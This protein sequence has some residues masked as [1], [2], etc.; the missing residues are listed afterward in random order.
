M[1]QRERLDAAIDA[2][3]AEAAGAGPGAA[4]AARRAAALTEG[5]GGPKALRAFS[6]A[7]RHD[8]LDAFPRLALA[9]LH[10]EAGDLDAARREAAAVLADA[11][12]EAARARAAFIL[13]ELARVRGAAAEARDAYAA[14]AR[15]EDALLSANP[16]DATAA[17]W[18]ARALGRLSELDAPEQ[19][20]KAR[21]G[22]EGALSILRALTAQIGEPPPLAADIADAE[23][24]YA[25]LLLD[26]GHAAPA[27]LHT[28]EATGRYEALILLE[29]NEPHW[30]AAL[31]EAWT[32]CA[33]AAFQSNAPDA[34]REA[35]DKALRLRLKLAD[36]DPNEAW[37][38]AGLWRA[39]AA[40]LAALGDKS[41][42]ADSALQAVAL[43]KRLHGEA[44]GDPAGARFL[45]HA[46][47]E[48]SDLALAQGALA[49][50]EDAATQ[51]RDLAERFAQAPNAAAHWTADCATAWD[52]LAH[53][54]LSTRASAEAKE[55]FAK[56]IALRRRAREAAP[57]DDNAKRALARA[58][59]RSG[60]V[61]LASRA[62]PAAL[63]AFSEAFQLRLELAEAAPGAMEPARELAV[64]L[65]RLGLSAAADGDAQ[66][67]R[68]VWEE[69]LAL[70]ERVYEDPSDI[71]GQRF[72]AV[73]EAHLASLG[74]P[75]S[76]VRR[77]SAL[78]R[79]DIMA[80]DGLLTPRDVQLRQSL[81]KTG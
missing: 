32:L 45:L 56:A 1:T 58:L 68:A 34:A 81:W 24:R 29:P 50:A 69:E 38:L 5:Q 78:A 41:A 18:Y 13:G 47:L 64:A 80:E 77:A 20:E 17:R 74:G 61:A 27:R 70:V 9:R 76:A 66:G 57:E 53:V 3:L 31:A 59:L 44:P 22:A 28:L 19:P 25:A 46:L 10:A 21:T 48:Q 2:L 71:E 8:P 39:R 14:A 11:I 26:E 60:E 30:R 6:L 67:A 16:T 12:D 75:D 73:I 55:A 23:F 51:A 37:A 72:R 4:M 7:V 15:I 52:R 49:T 54:A 63:A 40:L 79:L 42:A 33:E 36:A 35:I 65:E 43:C 62:H